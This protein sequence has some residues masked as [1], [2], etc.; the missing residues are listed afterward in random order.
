MDN[1]MSLVNFP[2]TAYSFKYMAQPM[3]KG[4]DKIAV[5]IVT[6]IVPTIAGKI[7]PSVIPFFGME[8]INSQLI[9]PKP[10]LAISYRIIS[11]AKNTIPAHILNKPKPKV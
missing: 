7:P 10:L 1:L 4:T 3:P 11:M 2:F 8:K 9:M 6:I 5:I